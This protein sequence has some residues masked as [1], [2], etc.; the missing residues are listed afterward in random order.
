MR[1][2]MGADTARG[3]PSAQSVTSTQFPGRLAISGHGQHRIVVA[4]I[5]WHKHRSGDGKVKRACSYYCSICRYVS[6]TGCQAN[7]VQ[8]RMYCQLFSITQNLTRVTVSGV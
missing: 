2:L 3:F 6:S 7:P 1:L 5:S 8:E 4:L